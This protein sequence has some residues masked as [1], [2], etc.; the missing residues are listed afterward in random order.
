MARPPRAAG[1]PAA[2]RDHARTARHRARRTVDLHRRAR[3][4]RRARLQQ[5]ARVAGE[6]DGRGRRLGQREAPQRPALGAR[7]SC[8]RSD[9]ASRRGGRAR[10]AGARAGLSRRAGCATARGDRWHA[11]RRGRGLGVSR[12]DRGACARLARSGAVRLPARPE[13]PLRLRASVQRRDAL[14]PAGRRR[15][16]HRAARRAQRHQGVDLGAGA[17]QRRRSGR[18]A[19]HRQARC[20]SLRRTLHR[21]AQ[22]GVARSV[23]LRCARAHALGEPLPRSARRRRRTARRR[24]GDPQG[25]ADRP[26]GRRKRRTAHATRRCGAGRAH[27]AAAGHWHRRG[28]RAAGAVPQLPG[29]ARGR[30]LALARRRRLRHRGRSR[31]ERGAGA[32]VAAR[33][34]LLRARRDGGPGD[35]RVPRR[36]AA[37]GRSARQRRRSRAR[38]Q[39]RAVRGDRPWRRGTRL[40][41][42]ASP[43]QAADGGQGDPPAPGERRVARALRPRSAAREPAH[44]S[45]HDRDLR[46]RAHARGPAVLRDGAAARTDAAADRRQQRPAGRGAR[47]PR[48]ARHRRFAVRGAR[49]RPRAS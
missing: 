21:R 17:R 4:A 43:A 16:A 25:P 42:A 38:R 15:R 46:L 47:D 40:P 10:R 30:S 48:A 49:T 9:G 41:R 13:R 14:R 39:L 18:G 33:S 24:V 32:A 27:A 1:A 26:R 34:R 6:R 31:R 20:R 8:R 22:R 45:E 11:A 37:H 36:A 19:R 28:Q 3:R 29:R 7:S 35:V 44:A 12:L 23:C 5:P 2:A